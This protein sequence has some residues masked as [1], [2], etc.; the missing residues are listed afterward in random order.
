MKHGM[1]PKA[2]H[3]HDS[4]RE[5]YCTFLPPERFASFSA[6]KGSYRHRCGVSTRP[7]DRCSARS[8]YV[9]YYNRRSSVDLSFL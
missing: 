3:F 7:V 2:I 6:A 9:L 8:G 4:F 1:P 5:L